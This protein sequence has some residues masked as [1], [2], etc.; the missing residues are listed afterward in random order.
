VVIGDN[1]E[2]CHSINSLKNAHDHG[3]RVALGNVCSHIFLKHTWSCIIKSGR[4]IRAMPLY[5]HLWSGAI[6]ER[7]Y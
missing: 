4:I 5:R 3:H 2:G 6:E 1:G 7:L